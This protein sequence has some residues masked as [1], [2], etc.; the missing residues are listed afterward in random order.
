MCTIDVPLSCDGYL[1]TIDV[2][3]SCDGYLCTI[4]VPLSCDGYLYL[5]SLIGIS[6]VQFD[7][8]RI[9]S[10]SSDKTI[11]VSRNYLFN[12]MLDVDKTYFL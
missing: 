5:F 7:D 1:C 6:C 10:G 12:E 8:T 11:K 4:D 2:P 9:V 3:L